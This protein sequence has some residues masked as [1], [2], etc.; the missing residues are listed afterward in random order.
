MS[1]AVSKHIKTYFLQTILKTQFDSAKLMFYVFKNTA[2]KYAPL[3]R[4]FSSN[5]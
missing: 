2:S 5:T 3:L 1:I 4:F